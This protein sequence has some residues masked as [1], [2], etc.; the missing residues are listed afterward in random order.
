VSVV[1]LLALLLS[2]GAMVL[3]DSRFRLFFFA[4]ARRATIVLA[5]GVAGF[6]A[7]DVAGIA[8]GL[9]SRGTT[10]Y[11]TGLLLTPELPVEELVFLTFLAYLTMNLYAGAARLLAARAGARDR[12]GGVP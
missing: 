2:L 4:D 3:L 6:L 10:P 7:W 9:F 12:A 1:Y 11:M 5:A 8:L